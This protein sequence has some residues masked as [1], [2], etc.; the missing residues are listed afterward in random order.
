MRP[1]SLILAAIV[2]IS[3]SSLAGSA[4]SGLPGIGTFA[5][6]DSTAAQAAPQIAGL[7]VR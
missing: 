4:E 6:A 7:A 3:G 1:T 2:V 5:Y